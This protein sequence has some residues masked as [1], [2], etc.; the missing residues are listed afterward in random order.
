MICTPYTFEG[1]IAKYPLSLIFI[2]DDSGR[3]SYNGR[4]YYGAN[5]EIL[6][7]D[8]H[9]W[10]KPVYGTNSGW[11]FY[12]NTIDGVFL[13]YEAETTLKPD[14]KGLPTAVYKYNSIIKREKERKR[15]NSAI[16]PKSEG[17]H[18]TDQIYNTEEACSIS[19]NSD[20]EYE[21]DMEVVRLNNAYDFNSIQGINDI[22]VPCVEVNGNSPTGKVEYYL[23]SQCFYSHWEAGN[24]ELALACLRKAQDL[25]YISDMIWKRDDFLRLVRYLYESG[26]DEEAEIELARID[27]FFAEQDITL[28]NIFT[29]IND[30]KLSGTDL[31]EVYSS[32]PCC[33][34][35]AKYRNRIFSISG[36]S[37]KFP[38]LPKAFTSENYWHKFSCLSFSPFTLG[39]NEPSFECKNIAKYSNRPFVANRTPEEIQ[40][41]SNWRAMLD[42][43]EAKQMQNE[44]AMIENAK[45]NYADSQTFQ[46]IQENLPSLCPKSLSGF[47]RMRTMNTKN[48][49][50]I[51]SE[52]AKQG[53]AL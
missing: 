6:K 26:K 8:I 39:I 24:K 46:W 44:I 32:G 7:A 21:R 36:T 20:Y 15:L 4:I 38:V 30:A 45:N 27:R 17:I 53:K 52:A 25:M 40:Q 33:E 9:I 1:R 29:A 18:G 13:L 47:R 31:I 41:Y 11:S 12:F 2:S 28:E 42:E 49:Q 16:P 19:D 43:A 37:R 35:C 23:R 5:G 22:T 48:Y 51:V 3:K 50:K 34:E 14:D 10:C